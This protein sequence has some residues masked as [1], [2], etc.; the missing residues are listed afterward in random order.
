MKLVGYPAT[1]ELMAGK[2]RAGDVQKALGISR[3]VAHYRR[4]HHGMPSSDSHGFI[5]SGALARFQM[6]RG[7]TRINWV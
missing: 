2:M 5:N 7:V 1:V 4:R 3:A 6:S